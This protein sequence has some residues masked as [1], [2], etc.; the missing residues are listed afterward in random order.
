M[1]IS[2]IKSIRLKIVRFN[3]TLFSFVS[4]LRLSDTEA[5]VSLYYYFNFFYCVPQH[6][7]CFLADISTYRRRNFRYTS[8][9]RLF[10][11]FYKHSGLRT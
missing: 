1:K 6:L 3:E 9:L 2:V 7:F 10:F 4:M 11:G 5:K 8:P